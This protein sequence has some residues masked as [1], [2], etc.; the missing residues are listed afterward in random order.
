MSGWQGLS[1]LVIG[2]Q[3][4]KVGYELPKRYIRERLLELLIC[5]LPL[6]MISWLVSAGCVILMVPDI[7]F[8]RPLPPPLGKAADKSMLI[9]TSSPP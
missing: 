3:L 8:V 5:L 4:V 7:S 6:M 2:I 1:R 9:K